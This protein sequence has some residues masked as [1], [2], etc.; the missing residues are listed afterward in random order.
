MAT[1][2]REDYIKA[3]YSKSGDS[4]VPVTTSYIAEK[5]SVSQA[6]ISDMLKK[7]NS[8]GM[9]EYKKYKGVVLTTKGK[10]AALRVLRRHRLWELFLMEVLGM[11]WDEV[12]IEAEKLEHETSD[13]LID[14]IEAYLN[15][16]K[17]DPHGAPIPNKDG[18]MPKIEDSI[19]LTQVS[20]GE[21]YEVL[22]VNDN[23]SELVKYLASIGL[24]LNSKFKVNEKRQFDNSVSIQ[25]N[26]SDVSLSST[27]C[28]NV[29]VKKIE[30]EV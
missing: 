17:L 23:N 13:S 24:V 19:P 22:R 18:V 11:D 12:H 7:L 8:E 14:K 5:L 10:L 26:N 21:D 25:I 3:I 16:P 20:S 6:A 29:F 2:S 4:G 30:E 27:I 9:V 15:Y 1:A 28:A